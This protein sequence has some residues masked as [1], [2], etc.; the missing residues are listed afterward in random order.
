MTDFL[1]AKDFFSHVLSHEMEPLIAQQKIM[2]AIREGKMRVRARKFVCGSDTLIDDFIPMEK[3]QSRTLYMNIDFDNSTATLGAFNHIGGQPDYWKGAAE[4]LSFSRRHT[5]A[6]WPEV[7]QV[8]NP[9]ENIVTE[10][11]GRKPAMDWEAVLIEA[12]VYMYSK[13]EPTY[14]LQELVTHI[15]NRF[16]QKDGG[17]T[18]STI[19]QHLS[20]LW[21]R[22]RSA[23]GL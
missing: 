1:N 6:I 9:G 14:T 8:S 12:A 22:F 15:Q 2:E 5:L 11:R 16:P 23:D 19:Q 20:P 13:Q 3:L 21:N 17:V 10:S 4:G 7:T 18:A